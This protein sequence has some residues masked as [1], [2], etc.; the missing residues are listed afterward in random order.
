MRFTALLVDD[1]Y[2]HASVIFA[3]DAF[4]GV[5][6]HAV[7]LFGCSALNVVLYASMYCASCGSGG[8]TGVVVDLMQP[9]MNRD[10]TIRSAMTTAS[11]FAIF[12]C[13]NVLCFKKINQI[14][15]MGEKKLKPF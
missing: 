4:I 6:S 7:K 11:F 8:V 13:F 10:A 1:G 2:V 5:R 14:H 12:A 15:C 9:A 3:D